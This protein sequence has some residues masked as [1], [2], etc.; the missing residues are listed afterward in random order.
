M[1]TQ[2]KGIDA[3]NS[4]LLLLKPDLKHHLFVGGDKR[5]LGEG[6]A[7]DAAFEVLELY[8]AG[9]SRQSSNECDVEVRGDEVVVHN[10]NETRLVDWVRFNPAHQEAPA[11]G[12]ISMIESGFGDDEDQMTARGNV[13]KAAKQ[14][15]V[16]GEEEISCVFLGSSSHTDASDVGDLAFGSWR[17][18]R[19]TCNSVRAGGGVL[20]PNPTEADF[21]HL[22]AIIHFCIWAERDID[23]PLRVNFF[24]SAELFPAGCYRR[25]KT[26]VLQRAIA[27]FRVKVSLLSVPRIV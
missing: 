11:G 17:F 27:E 21:D 15:P 9:I 1:V 23:D 20:D 5:E 24:R 26:I 10:R 14:I 4:K 7:I 13:L 3:L 18:D 8:E 19:T 2:R 12:S 22:Q 25:Q 16:P 6:H